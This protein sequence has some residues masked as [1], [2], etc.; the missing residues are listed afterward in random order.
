M[1]TPRERLNDLLERR[2]RSW[3]TAET[4]ITTAAERGE[5]LSAE[6]Q[7]SW[8]RARDEVVAQTGQ[9][10]TLRDH[11][12]LAGDLARVQRDDIPVG[13]DPSG[14][15]QRARTVDSD[16]YRSAFARYLRGGDQGLSSSQR[17]MLEQARANLPQASGDDTLGGYLVPTEFA[18]QIIESAHSFNSLVEAG[19]TVLPTSTGVEIQYPTSDDVEEGEIIAENQAVTGQELVFG[20]RP[21]GAHIF[22][23]KMV[24][25]PRSLLSDSRIPLEPFLRNALGKR[26]GRRQARAYAVGTGVAQPQ[27]VVTAAQV[28]QVAAAPTA[29]TYSDFVE[30]RYDAVDEAYD[31]RASWLFARGTLAAIMRILDA[32]GRP[33]F[34]PS[35]NPTQ[36]D[37]ILGRPFRTNTYM[38]GL[39][40]GAKPILY[41]D[42]A[43]YLIREVDGFF[44]QRLVERYAEFFQVAF[45]GFHRADGALLDTGAVKALQMAAA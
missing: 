29:I 10:D 21:I 3:E 43:G 23:S 20:M 6:E 14:D 38:P 42:F 22:S 30:M 24:K 18:N 28:A 41:G 7:G 35:P 8:Q 13:P 45:I 31:D 32:D 19:A 40:A 33:I 16:E 39:V 1:S 25:V 34:S 5:D 17:E 27:G 37:T 4:I 12:G 15:S 11:L 44:L 36:P 2:Q 26:I 9:I